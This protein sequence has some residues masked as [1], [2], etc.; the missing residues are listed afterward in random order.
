MG[1]DSTRTADLFIVTE[2]P[3]DKAPRTVKA[4][5]AKRSQADTEYDQFAESLRNSITNF[6]LEG[7]AIRDEME[8]MIVARRFIGESSADSIYGPI[9][10]AYIT[11]LIERFAKLKSAIEA[12]RPDV[13]RIIESIWSEKYGRYFNEEIHKQARQEL[14]I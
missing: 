3:S 12:E 7:R 14:G 8:R 4:H 2:G 6:C 9:R 11:Y 1:F 13:N 10:G 5:T